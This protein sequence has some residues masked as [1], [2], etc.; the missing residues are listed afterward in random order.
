MALAEGYQN[1]ATMLAL[2]LDMNF[3]ADPVAPRFVD[4]LTPF[5]PTGAGVGTIRL[6]LQLC[7]CGPASDI[8]GQ[9]LTQ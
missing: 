4:L 5:R 7:R 8:P 3:F 1:L 9:R 2:S 6:L